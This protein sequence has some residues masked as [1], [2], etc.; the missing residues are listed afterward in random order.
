MTRCE[1][2]NDGKIYKL[3][4]AHLVGLQIYFFGT[5]HGISGHERGGMYDND[6][7]SYQERLLG[8]HLNRTSIA[9]LSS[10]SVSAT[11]SIGT[12][13]SPSNMRVMG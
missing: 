8:N 13:R 7:D 10:I 6:D 9:S 11:V 3:P 4:S 5:E 12:R 2:K 1:A